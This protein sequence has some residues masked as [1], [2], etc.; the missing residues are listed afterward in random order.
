MKQRNS[1]NVRVKNDPPQDWWM[2]TD[3]RLSA[4]GSL[5]MITRTWCNDWWVGFTGGVTVYLEDNNQNIIN[6]SPLYT[7]GVNATTLS[8]ESPSD[9]TDRRNH[10]FSSAEYN[11]TSRLR[12]WHGHTPQPRLGQQ[13]ERGIWIGKKVVEIIA[14]FGGSAS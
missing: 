1:G 5:E 7:Y 10:Q 12:I 14:I 13:I 4:N 11:A 8:W 6:S 3:A 9:R 2:N